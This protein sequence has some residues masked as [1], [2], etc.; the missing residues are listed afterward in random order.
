MT[1]SPPDP[2]P[3]L[4][5]NSRANLDRLLGEMLERPE[6][7]AEIV[8]EIDREF[9]E[10]R[11]VMVLDM[12]GFARTTRDRGITAFLLMIHQM[13]LIAGSVVSAHGGIV[14]KLEA[15]NLYSLFENSAAAVSAAREIMRQL[16]TLNLLLPEGRR[17]Y[18]SVGIGYGRILNVD[19]EDLFGDEVN[20]ASKLG[21][22]V[23]GQGAILLTA[24]A[25]A[26][27]G[28]AGLDSREEKIV[29]SGLSL[30]YYALR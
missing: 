1:D 8:A 23:A 26:E 11:A 30:T 16:T 10:V 6:D 17:L 28:Q 18:A 7:Q 22:D 12:T 25:R 20:L 15:D 14:V 2:K 27:A 9:G 29:I 4:R 21:E 24:A 5:R 13:K 3:G 19:E